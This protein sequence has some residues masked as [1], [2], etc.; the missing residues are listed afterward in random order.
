[1]IN[2]AES[3]KVSTENILYKCGWSPFEGETFHNTIS[4]T[5]VTERLLLKMALFLKSYPE[6]HLNLK[7]TKTFLSEIFVYCSR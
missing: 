1:M 5:F 6:K 7:I 4:K 3:Y 2:P